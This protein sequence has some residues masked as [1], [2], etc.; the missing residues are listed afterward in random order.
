MSVSVIIPAA[1]FGRRM[2]STVNKQNL[3]LD[4]RPVLAHTID[5]FERHH[6]IDH[7]VLVTAA[8][9]VDACCTEIVERFGFTKVVAVVAGG[10]ERQDSVRLGLL[11]CPGDD[12]TVVLVH[13]GVRPFFCGSLLPEL[14]A[15]V[16]KEGACIVAVPVKDTIKQVEEGKIVSTPDRKSLW[17]AQTPQGFLLGPLRKAHEAAL[18]AGFRGTDDASLLERMGLPV[19]VLEGNYRNIKITTPEDMVLARAFIVDSGA[20]QG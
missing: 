5:L 19:V 7:I 13:D 17:Q 12:A 10:D 1:G 18:L 15:R 4:G 8:S 20:I 16:R 11:A 2:R 9:E 3:L 14:V 6:L